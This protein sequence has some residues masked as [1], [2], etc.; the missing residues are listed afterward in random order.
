MEPQHALFLCHDCLGVEKACSPVM[1]LPR[2]RVWMS[3][4]PAQDVCMGCEGVWQGEEH[5][6]LS[7][8]CSNSIIKMKLFDQNEIYF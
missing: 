7:S 8:E 5:V 2:I 1:A 3:C 6:N 4:V